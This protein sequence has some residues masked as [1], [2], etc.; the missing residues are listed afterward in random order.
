MRE[1]FSKDINGYFEHPEEIAAES[2]G[3]APEDS[4]FS[5]LDLVDIQ[6]FEDELT[7]E[8]MIKIGENRYASQLECLTIRFAELNDADPM[9]TG[10]PVHIAQICKSF[11]HCLESR[12]I[13]TN[14]ARQML[15]G[16]SD[17]YKMKRARQ[18]NVS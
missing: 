4:E 7:L 3:P 16:I 14:I 10:L 9:K 11:R 13:P 17:L 5:E 1:V 12:G 2:S 6:D 18:D 8:R 15:Y